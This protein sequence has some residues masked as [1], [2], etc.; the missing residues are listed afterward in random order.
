M[1]HDNTDSVEWQLRGELELFLLWFVCCLPFAISTL[2]LFPCVLTHTPEE[3][4]HMQTP[5]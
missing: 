5:G 1:K 4:D 2:I 3:C